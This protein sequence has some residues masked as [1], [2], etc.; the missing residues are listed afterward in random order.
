MILYLFSLNRRAAA[1]VVAEGFSYFHTGAHSVGNEH[2]VRTLGFY[3]LYLAVRKSKK[4]IQMCALSKL[5][6]SIHDFACSNARTRA[7]IRV[8]TNAHPAF[9]I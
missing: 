8:P 9:A 4:D 3:D 6:V 1:L 5:L 2:E 7:A